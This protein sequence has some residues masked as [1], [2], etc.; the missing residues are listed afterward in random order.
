MSDIR[1]R[2]LGGSK[3]LQEIVFA[4]SH[5]ASITSGSSSAQ[6]QD[7][8]IG[9][10]AAAGV[11]LFDLRILARKFKDGGASLVGY[12]GVARGKS[13]SQFTSSHTGKTQDVK[14]NSDIMGEFGQKLSTM[15]K[16]GKDFV[17]K[18][19]EFLIFKFDKCSN[20]P[21]VA[22]YCTKLLGTAIYKPI[23]IEFSKLTLNDLKKKVVCVFNDGALKEM[24][25]YG[26][27]D[28]ILGF[29]SLKGKDG[30]G[31]YDPEYPGLQYYGKGGTDWKKIY[32]TNN[33]KMKDNQDIQKKMLLAMARQEDDFAANVLGMMYWTSTGFTSSIRKRNENTMWGGTG[34]A[35]MGQ[36]W[37]EGLEASISTQLQRDQIKTLTYKGVTR[38]KAYFP[39][40]IMID[41]ADPGK[42]KTIY[43][44]NK[45]AEEKLA[46][47]YNK[48]AQG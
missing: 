5:D 10:Q 47:A 15:L 33:M 35:R 30:V 12:H 27:K 25:G 7:L 19:G 4:G 2:D 11:R 3:R 6:T 34:V 16:Q 42:C 1:Y 45:V 36:L 39:N 32:Q 9:G 13:T 14:T 37:R 44:L 17:E 43:D 20:Y 40:I 41:F 48:Y 18:T 46:A 26:A 31:V 8:D 29:R 24:K 22:D 38:M 23:G 21:L 28:G